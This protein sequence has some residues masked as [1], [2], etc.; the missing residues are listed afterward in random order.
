MYLK[1]R[2]QVISLCFQFVDFIHIVSGNK[3]KLKKIKLFLI[4]KSKSLYTPT[5]LVVVFNHK[6]ARI[7]L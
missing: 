4:T 6:N 1:F 5:C 7:S 3:F 2:Y